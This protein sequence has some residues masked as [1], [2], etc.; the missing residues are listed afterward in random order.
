MRMLISPLHAMVRTKIVLA[1]FV[2]QTQTACR[3][4]EWY[5]VQKQ[6]GHAAAETRTT[7]F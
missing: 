3:M 2:P 7:L 6:A 4:I 5:V 1:G